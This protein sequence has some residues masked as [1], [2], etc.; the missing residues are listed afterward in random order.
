MVSSVCAVTWKGKQAA[1]KRLPLNTGPTQTSI[2]DRLTLLTDLSCLYCR[3]HEGLAVVMLLYGEARRLQTE[4]L[5]DSI[6]LNP[7]TCSH[8]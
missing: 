1:N 6:G 2:N 7:L 5:S 3:G 8:C 4:G